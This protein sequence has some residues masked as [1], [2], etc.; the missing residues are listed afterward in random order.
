M[1]L[2][3]Q[4]HAFP[5]VVVLGVRLLDQKLFSKIVPSYSHQQYVTIPTGCALRRWIPT[6]DN[7]G[8]GW[9]CDIISG[10]LP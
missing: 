7:Q 2:D 1:Y 5:L 6:G 4:V 8:I 9:G 10:S 3:A